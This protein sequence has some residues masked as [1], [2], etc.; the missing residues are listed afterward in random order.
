ML[1]PCSDDWARAIASRPEDLK[2]AFPASV[3]DPKVIETM[4]DKWRFAN[5]VE[6]ANIPRPRTTQVESMAQLESLPKNSSKAL[7]RAH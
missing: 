6:C 3:A 4:T 5:F 7:P 2:A 1:I